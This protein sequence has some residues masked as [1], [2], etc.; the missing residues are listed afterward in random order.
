LKK[1]LLLAAVVAGVAALQAGAASSANNCTFTTKGTTMSLNG[2]CTTDSTLLV[3]NGYTLDGKGKTITGVDPVG[4][5]FTG[6]VVANAGSTANVKNLTVTVS[7][8]ANVCDAGAARL[9]GIMFDGASGQI[10]H[11]T[12]VNVTQA[13]SGCQ[14]GNSI[15][16]RNCDGAP[17][18]NVQ[19]DH[20]T[21][22]GFMKTGILTNCDVTVSMDHNDIGAS[23]NQAY[24]AANSIQLGFGAGGS[25]DHNNLD[26]NQWCGPSDDVATG[27]LLFSNGPASVDHNKIGGNS[28]V[29]IYAGGDNTSVTHNDVKDSG[30]DCNV[31]GYDIGIGNYGDADPTT[32]DVSFNSVSGF[33]VPFDGPVGSH[34]K[35]KPSH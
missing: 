4:G 27:M 6:A 11:N 5:H 35:V 29:G 18:T 32:N 31:N 26:G 7:N 21:V 23:A 19:I 8:L 34:N 12:V 17:H 15:E 3:P 25:I 33:D 2:N 9:R 30:A 10:T 20:N 24:L 28:D 1:F 14:E 13:A 16:A 22:T